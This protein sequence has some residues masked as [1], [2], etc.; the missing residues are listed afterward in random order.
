M[1]HGDR[2]LERGFV[3]SLPFRD[4]PVLLLSVATSCCSREYWLYL[5]PESHPSPSVGM[6]ERLIC[7]PSFLRSPQKLIFKSNLIRE[8]IGCCCSYLV[9][10]GSAVR[11]AHFRQTSR[12]LDAFLFLPQ[13]ADSL[14]Q[15][16]CNGANVRQYSN[17][18]CPWC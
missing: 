8:P 6:S 14:V 5:L 9:A 2:K 16:R 17:R 13:S 12:K 18:Y 7:L 1:L 3:I 10:T 4:P 11:V 15:K